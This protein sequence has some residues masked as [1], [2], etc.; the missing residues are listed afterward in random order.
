MATTV[1]RVNPDT[2][3][4]GPIARA[5]AVLRRGGLVAFPTETVYGLGANALDAAAVARIFE[6]KGR[7]PNNPVIVHVA[8]PADALQVCAAWPESAARLAARFWP[9]PLTLVL[10][11]KPQVPE[12]VTAGG[13]TVGVRL[14]AHPVARALI[15]AAGVPVAAPSANRSNRLSPTTAQ[16]VLQDLEGRIDMILDAG[17]APGGLESTVLDLASTPPR[18]LRP[19]LVPPGEIEAIIGP[20]D[21]PQAPGPP[22]AALPSPG[23]LPRHYAPRAPLE[24]TTD[25]GQRRAEELAAGG[26]RVGWLTFAP[27]PDPL[28]AGVTV[29]QLS[30]DPTAVAAQ[31][32]AALHQLDDAAVERIVVELPPDAEEWLAVRD[33]L[34]RASHPPAGHAGA[35][36]VPGTDA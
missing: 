18:L 4:P 3:E 32:Y 27:L 6:A 34:R 20:I 16:H 13:P 29:L 7:P 30:P 2:P 25:S 19:G 12:A 35:E 14:P 23:M 33:R 5:A 24:C 36:K 15:A 22:P 9:G 28:P 8:E 17:P 10:P 11:R 31:L 21:R 1:F 26:V